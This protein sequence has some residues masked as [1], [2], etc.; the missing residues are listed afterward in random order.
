MSIP[1]EGEIACPEWL[2]F[3]SSKPYMHSRWDF[4][5]GSECCC[6]AVPARKL[7]NTTIAL[8][9]GRQ[10]ADAFREP[11]L[12]PAG[13]RECAGPGATSGP[14]WQ[15]LSLRSWGIAMHANDESVCWQADAKTLTPSGD[16]C[17]HLQDT[18]SAQGLEQLWSHN[19]SGRVCVHGVL[20][21]MRMMRA[22]AGRRMPKC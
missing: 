10:D 9:G 8:A 19:G 2:S 16:Q 4:L 22:C 17:W 5:P 21:C 15:R 13:H 7:V 20:Q 3:Q 12:A 6:T 18:A 14:Q 1:V 11:V